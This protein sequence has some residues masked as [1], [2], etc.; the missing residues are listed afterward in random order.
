[1]A[2]LKALL[3]LCVGVSQVNAQVVL[4]NEH[5]QTEIGE[6]GE[7][8][9]PNCHMN[10]TYFGADSADTEGYTPQNNNEGELIS[11]FNWVTKKCEPYS[12]DTLI[13]CAP[14]QTFAKC[15]EG[16]KNLETTQAPTAR[17][18]SD[19]TAMEHA[20]PGAQSGALVPESCDA[21]CSK[22][23][24]AWWNTCNSSTFIANLPG[25]WPCVRAPSYD[26]VPNRSLRVLTP[27][28]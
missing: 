21:T 5:D 26:S 19:T 20:C 23:F 11:G 2:V 6:K 15:R 27:K 28:F 10:L 18:C 1:M 12:D 24:N 7:K 8:H 3:L 16:C 22:A 13:P 25:A 17:V 9:S 4:C 14:F